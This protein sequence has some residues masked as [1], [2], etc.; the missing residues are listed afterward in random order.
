MAAFIQL[1]L[2]Y[3]NIY[4]CIDFK[5]LDFIFFS[6]QIQQ[7]TKISPFTCWDLKDGSLVITIR[8]ATKL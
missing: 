4:F 7:T 2:V 8:I 1:H 5:Y 3:I 6:T